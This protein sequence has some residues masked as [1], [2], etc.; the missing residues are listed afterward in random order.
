M[1]FAKLKALLK[2]AAARTIPALH[3]AIASALGCFTSHE[4]RNYFTAAGY[5]PE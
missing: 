4:C 2:A 1:A 5:D 3:D